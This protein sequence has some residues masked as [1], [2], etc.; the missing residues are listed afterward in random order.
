MK[1]THEKCVCSFHTATR[2]GDEHGM[3]TD[4]KIT[5]RCVGMHQGEDGFTL[6]EIMV[7][8]VVVAVLRVIGGLSLQGVLAGFR[9]SNTPR[10]VATTLHAARLK[11]IS[12]HTNYKVALYPATSYQDACNSNVTV[13]PPSYQVYS[14]SSGAWVCDGKAVRLPTTVKFRDSNP[15]TFTN[16]E[17]VFTPTGVLTPITPGGIYLMGAKDQQQYRITVVGLTGRIK[18]WKGWQ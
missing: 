18:V 11:A 16:D 9:A 3:S 14:N 4:R 10:Q 12:R 2:K 1:I 17:V 15:T 6:A 8:L 5:A 7:G 13:N